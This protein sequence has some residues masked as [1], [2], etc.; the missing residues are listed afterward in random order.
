M[1]VR[2]LRDINIASEGLATEKLTA[3]KQTAEASCSNRY[4]LIC[5]S[6]YHYPGCR[7]LEGCSW[8]LVL[9]LWIL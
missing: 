8:S 6:C 7:S 9:C 4:A 2:Q 3:E 5:W 1:F